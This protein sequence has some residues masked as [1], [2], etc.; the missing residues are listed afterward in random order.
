RESVPRGRQ[1][2]ELERLVT[3]FAS[4][5]RAGFQVITLDDV[6]RHGRIAALVVGLGERD[7]FYVPVAHEQERCLEVRDVLQRFAAS[8]QSAKPSKLGFTQR[9]V[10]LPLRAQGPA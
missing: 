1:V 6:P 10:S 8:L 9:A 4:A 2:A 5:G 7:V 3:A